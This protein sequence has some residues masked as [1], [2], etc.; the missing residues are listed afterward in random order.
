MINDAPRCSRLHDICARFPY[1]HIILRSFSEC[2][3]RITQN[4]FATIRFQSTLRVISCESY[5]G[6]AD[7]DATETRPNSRKTRK[8]TVYSGRDLRR[9]A[10]ARNHDLSGEDSARVL[11]KHSTT[12]E[13][14]AAVA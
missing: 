4:T 5:A 1:F 10:V 12:G 2:S 13:T 7:G 6:C 14:F 9:L 8:I 3:N 11:R